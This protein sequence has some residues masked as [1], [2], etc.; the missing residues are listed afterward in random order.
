[1]STRRRRKRTQLSEMV[2]RRARD[3]TALVASIR[4][5][6]ADVAA[7]FRERF[8]PVL[9]PGETLPDY[10]LALELA[11]R[12]V[13]RAFD[14]LDELDDRQF[15][16]KSRRAVAACE[17]ERLAKKELYPQAVGVR[18]QIDDAFGR[19]AGAEIHGFS[20][21]TPRTPARLEAAGRLGVG[22]RGSGGRG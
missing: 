22:R 13:Q 9:G 12:S 2:T 8:G 1:M 10:E 14:R 20:G 7:A 21:R 19:Q 11:G 16:A 6:K 5:Y 17:V 4:V 18:R 15:F 3:T